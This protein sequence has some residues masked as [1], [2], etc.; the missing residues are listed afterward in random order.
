MTPEPTL[1]GSASAKADDVESARADAFADALGELIGK[2]LERPTAH[3]LGKLFQKRL[4]GRP[5]WIGDGQ[6]VAT[7]QKSTG[8]SENT[9]RVVVSAPEQTPDVQ[10]FTDGSAANIGRNIPHIP[11]IPQDGRPEAAKMGNLGKE[12]NV[13]AD[14]PQGNAILDGDSKETPAWRARL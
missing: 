6:T 14:A 7:Q 9:Y 13:F 5:A 10:P 12:G 8:H 4:V 2:R 11:H 3:S 1:D